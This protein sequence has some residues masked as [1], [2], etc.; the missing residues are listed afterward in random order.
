[1]MSGNDVLIGEDGD[2]DGRWFVDG[3]SV[4]DVDIGEAHW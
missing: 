2:G 1:M 3:E 4:E